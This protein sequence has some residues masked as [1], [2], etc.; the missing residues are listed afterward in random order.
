MTAKQAHNL[1]TTLVSKEQRYIVHHDWLA[2]MY[3]ILAQQASLVYS[4]LYMQSALERNIFPDKN[5]VALVPT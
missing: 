5:E 4:Y 2:I 3:P 1:D